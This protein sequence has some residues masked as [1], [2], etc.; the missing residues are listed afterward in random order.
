M[1]SAHDAAGDHTRRE[2]PGHPND[3]CVVE[4]VFGAVGAQHD[5]IAWAK[6]KVEDLEIEPDLA[7]VRGFLGQFVIDGQLMGRQKGRIAANG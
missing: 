2:T 3:L 1:S 6:R 7:A 5:R 4:N